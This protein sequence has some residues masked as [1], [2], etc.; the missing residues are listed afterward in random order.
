MTL[1]IVL[2]ALNAAILYFIGKVGLYQ[3]DK[4]EK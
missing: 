2:L 3:L 1:I 4:E